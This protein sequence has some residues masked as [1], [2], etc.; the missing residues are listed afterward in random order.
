MKK[1]FPRT[2]FWKLK[3]KKKKESAPH[4]LHRCPEGGYERSDYQKLY[5]NLYKLAQDGAKSMVTVTGV[6][7]DVDW[8]NN[9]YEKKGQTAG[10]IVADNGKELMIPHRKEIVEQ[11]EKVHVT[12]CDNNCRPQPP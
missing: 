5:S 6:V 7:S 3:P 10:L 2:W 1:C 11:A 12:F 4:R 8:L 9:T